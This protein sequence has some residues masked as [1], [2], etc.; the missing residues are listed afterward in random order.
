MTASAQCLARKR[1][2]GWWSFDIASQPQST[3]VITFIFGPYFA[4]VVG[5]PV[6][7]QSLWALTLTGSGLFIALAA[8]VMG[9]MADRSGNLRGWVWGLSA[10]LV[11][12]TFSLW[13]ATPGS[14]QFGLIL[15]AVALSVVAVEMATIVT[16]AM[17]PGLA[18]RSEI[19]R[20]SGTGFAVGYGGGLISLIV[21]LLFFAE[22]ASGVTL[23]GWPPAFGLDPEMREGTRFVGPF[24]ALWYV[25]FM[26]PFFIW[27]RP[28][29]AA[30]TGRTVA[31]ALSDL[32]RT[33]RSLPARRSLFAYLGASMF[34][35]DAL[36]GLYSFGGLYA[37]GVLS[38]SV[39]Q[40]GIFGIAGL[41][42]AAVASWIG[43]RMDHTHGP[44]PVITA[45][46][47]ILTTVSIA[48]VSTTRD[49]IFGV[50]IAPGSI[51]P[52]VVMYICGALIGGAGGAL[53][54]ASRTMMVHHADPARPSEAFGLYALSGKA[55][56]FLAPLLIGL[57]TAASG[58]QR[59]GISP[60]IVLFLAGLFLLVWVSK[61]GDVVHGEPA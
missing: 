48:L 6:R 7:A 34:Y 45:C 57:A 41:V 24:T 26:V 47:V 54:S 40:L 10:L 2:L 23:L 51:A 55:T 44:K 1:I 15:L 53:Q 27:V 13:G 31:A 17:L 29:P 61:D 39:T 59:I 8:P 5:D 52:D 28:A 37:I 3:L 19:G 20:V 12:S 9:A 21:M 46:I 58:D 25:V 18:P 11:L 36:N 33:L 4:T 35:R 38:W 30:Q 16:N 32:G 22:N 14:T 56:A 60:L 43:G 42:S 49:T 50:P